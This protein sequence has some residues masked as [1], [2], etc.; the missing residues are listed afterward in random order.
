M[1]LDP[2]LVKVTF[3]DDE[4]TGCCLIRNNCQSISEVP[5]NNAVGIPEDRLTKSKKTVNLCHAGLY[6][7]FKPDILT[8]G[9]HLITLEAKGKN[10]RMKAKILVNLLV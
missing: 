10:F 6:C 7:I 2:R 9:D 4:V 8:P 5:N 1:E 3:D